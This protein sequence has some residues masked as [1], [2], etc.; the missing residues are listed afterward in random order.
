MAGEAVQKA[1]QMG[2]SEG[3]IRAV[4]KYR[5]EHYGSPFKNAE[6][7]VDAVLDYQREEELQQQHGDDIDDDDEQSSSA[8]VR[9][10]G[11][12]LDTIFSHDSTSSSYSDPSSSRIILDLNTNENQN[13]VSL[14]GPSHSRSEYISLP[15]SSS[16]L[17]SFTNSQI[18]NS[19][20]ASPTSSILTLQQPSFATNEPKSSSTRTTTATETTPSPTS[21]ACSIQSVP[22]GTADNAVVKNETKKKLS[23][24]EENRQLKDARL[25]KVC[26]DD[27]VAVVFL[28]CG[29]LGNSKSFIS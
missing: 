20:N 4:T 26:M 15:T 18:T 2:L 17:A 10:V 1:L 16:A 13:L 23:L 12:I 22:E 25:C 24:E 14:M 21:I 7:L 19:I 5:L 11:R 6:A 8:I 28:P 9:E 27:D 29:H 3:R